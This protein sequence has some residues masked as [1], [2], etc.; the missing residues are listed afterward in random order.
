MLLSPGEI[1]PAWE[2]GKVAGGRLVIMSIKSE[3]V[4]DV[5]RAERGRGRGRED[6]RLR[7]GDGVSIDL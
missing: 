3:S 2:P 5:G 1:A 7:T 4:G 6:G